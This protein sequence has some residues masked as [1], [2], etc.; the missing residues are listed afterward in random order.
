MNCPCN[1]HSKYLCTRIDIIAPHCIIE[2]LLLPILRRCKKI[3]GFVEGGQKKIFL[4]QRLSQNGHSRHLTT[5][6]TM[7]STGHV[8]CPPYNP[9]LRCPLTL[10]TTPTSVRFKLRVW[11]HR[12][13]THPPSYVRMFVLCELLCL[14]NGRWCAATMFDL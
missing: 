10:T 11:G 1:L 6:T 5:V 3:F 13:S 14:A 4:D 2:L 9:V 8:L 7:V 12:I